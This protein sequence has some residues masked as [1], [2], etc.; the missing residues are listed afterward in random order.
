MIGVEETYSNGCDT[1]VLERVKNIS[2]AKPIIYIPART[3]EDVEEDD[4]ILEIAKK[5]DLT[6]GETMK[7][8]PK[9]LMIELS[10]HYDP[11]SDWL[12][13]KKKN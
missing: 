12:S 1:K 10:S 11:I 2:N 9:E 3:V 8:I 6:E 13:M 5:V 4:R 7:G